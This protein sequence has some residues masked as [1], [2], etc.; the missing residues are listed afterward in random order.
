[1][2]DIILPFQELLPYLA[3]IAPGY[4]SLLVFYKWKWGNLKKWWKIP[5]FDKFMLSAIIGSVYFLTTTWLLTMVQSYQQLSTLEKI[6]FSMT[7]QMILFSIIVIL[8]AVMNFLHFK[9]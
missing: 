2:S 8:T 9:K 1:M 5:T 7:A 4:I 6:I 3:A